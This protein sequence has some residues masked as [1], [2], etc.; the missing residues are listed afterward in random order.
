MHI[1]QCSVPYYEYNTVPYE[2]LMRHIKGIHWLFY[3][4]SLKVLFCR[5]KNVSH[6]Y[7]GWNTDLPR[8][9]RFHLLKIG[10]TSITSFAFVRGSWFFFIWSALEN[11]TRPENFIVRKC[12]QQCHFLNWNI[13]SDQPMRVEYLVACHLVDQS[14]EIY[15]HLS[16]GVRRGQDG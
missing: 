8:L 11:A 1:A 15:G 14:E 13:Q 7:I 5:D 12:A 9:A 10:K 3:K 2:A 6:R 4:L 16:R